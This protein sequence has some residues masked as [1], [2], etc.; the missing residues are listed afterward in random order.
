VPAFAPFKADPAKTFLPGQFAHRYLQRFAC[1]VEFQTAKVYHIGR[2]KR[3]PL[4]SRFR[5]APDFF[6]D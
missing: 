2:R 4:D 5:C 3:I 1:L 6:Y